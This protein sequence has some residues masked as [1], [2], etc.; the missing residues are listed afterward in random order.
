MV[1]ENKNLIFTDGAS[2][3]NPGRGGW[4]AIIASNDYVWELGGAVDMTTNNRMEIQAVLAALE[5]AVKRGLREVTLYTDSAYVLNGATK[6]L[7]G[8]KARG[9]QTADSGTARRG[10][11][12]NRDL[13]LRMDELLRRIKIDWRQLRGHVGIMGNERC[14]DIATGWADGQL[15]P[16]YDGWR[17][18]YPINLQVSEE[19]LGLSA[20][21]GVKSG[22]AYSYVAKIGEEIKIFKAWPECESWVKGKSAPKFRKVFSADEEVKL[23]EEWR[24]GSNAQA[25]DAVSGV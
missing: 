15:V 19:Q 14:D 16:L 13:W 9:W 1:M 25:L 2:R 21:K 12:A 20:H 10:E 11:V 22:K 7:K 4:G 17:K 3:G 24:G 8:W 18:D 23:I 5:L 6:W